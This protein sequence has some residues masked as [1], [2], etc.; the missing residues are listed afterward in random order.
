MGQRGAPCAAHALSSRT[1][2]GPPAPNRI[3]SL[4]A[5]MPKAELHLHLEGSIEPSTVVELAARY[6]VHLT[7]EGARA[8]YAYTDFL[9]F[10]EAFKW[11]TSF[12]R[13]PADYS[14]I[15]ERLAER[16]LAQNVVYTEITIAGGVMLL[17]E[18]DLHANFAPLRD[19][20]ARLRRKGLRIQW[21]IDATR[22]FGA[23]AAMEVARL[24]VPLAKEGVVALGLG[25]DELAVPTVEFRRV[26]DFAAANGLHR[27]AH[28]GE[29][30]G[31]ES[32]REAIELLGAERIG[33]GIAAFR[34]PALMDLLTARRI[35]LEICS[36]SNFYT[37]ALLHQLRHTR[38]Q[39]VPSDTVRDHILDDALYVLLRGGPSRVP[40]EI[41]IKVL[42]KDHPLRSILRHGVPVTLSTDDPSMFHT[43]LNQEY[44]LA[45]EMGLSATEI[46]QVAQ[47]SFEHAF[48]ES[49]EKTSLLTDFRAQVSSL[50]LL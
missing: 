25:G 35:P 50:G 6:G 33:H 13:A 8:R 44:V 15:A 32:V 34:D 21:I 18:Q 31:P 37:G 48:L 4:L 23:T 5:T 36:T 49:A 41:Q 45:N 43:T 29:I 42:L 38:P 17:R 12:L 26:Y 1:V 40:V 47:A 11:V 24:S 46:V 14:L 22:Q 27:H 19:V 28:A 20:A 2:P 39:E 30:G 3:V 9:G 16:L 7:L 10:L